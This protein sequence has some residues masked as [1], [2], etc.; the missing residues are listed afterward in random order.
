MRYISILFALS[1]TTCISGAAPGASTPGSSGVSSGQGD[2]SGMIATGASTEGASPLDPPSTCSF[3]EVPKGYF[4]A[5]VE[6]IVLLEAHVVSPS[7][8]GFRIFLDLPHADDDGKRFAMAARLPLVDFTFDNST[9]LITVVKAEGVL[10]E[11]GNASLAITTIDQLSEV[12]GRHIPAHLGVQLGPGNFKGYVHNTDSLSL[13][14]MAVLSRTSG[15]TDWLAKVKGFQDELMDKD[16]WTLSAEDEAE[17][18]IPLIGSLPPAP[19]AAH[20]LVAS[21][22]SSTSPSVLLLVAVFAVI[23]A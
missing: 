10:R 20:D 15:P 12:V 17:L 18:A 8:M 23:V 14:N 5:Q 21:L 11:L 7:R 22:A 3:A 4:L 2:S 1:I 6:E 19:R 9:C 16:D 13:L